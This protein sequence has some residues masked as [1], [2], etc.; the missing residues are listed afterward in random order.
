MFSVKGRTVSFS[1]SDSWGNDG[2]SFQNVY[3]HRQHMRNAYYIMCYIGT[4]RCII[5]TLLP[6]HEERKHVVLVSKHS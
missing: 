1:L 2:I 4:L 5:G 3:G 6:L